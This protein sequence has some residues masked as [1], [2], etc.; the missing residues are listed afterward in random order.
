MSERNECAR[1]RHEPRF[2]DVYMPAMWPL[3]LQYY[4]TDWLRAWRQRRLY[5]RLLQLEDCELAV[6]DLDR[7]R[8]RPLAER[9][10]RQAVAE[11]RRCSGKPR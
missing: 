10:L 9:P 11:M 7:A 1:E 2:P 4:L 6:R 5:R 3:D 8:L